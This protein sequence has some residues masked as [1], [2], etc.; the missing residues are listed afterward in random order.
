LLIPGSISYVF[1]IMMTSLCKEYYQFIL[2]QGVL[3]GISTGFLFTPSLAVISHYFRK[4]RG[5]AMGVCSAGASLGGLLFPIGLKHALYSERLGFQW[6]VRV[7]GFTILGLLC[8]SCTLL[9]GRLPPRRGKLLLLRAFRQPS[10][11]ILISAIF[12]S[13]WATWVPYFFIVSFAL[14][15]IHT[16][17]NLSFYIFP[18]L[19][20]GLSLDESFRAS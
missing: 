1:S 3:G 8:I 7:I 11:S 18:S 2:A 20:R 5:F 13:L 17:A 4:K 10:Y 12:L 19:T 16:D 14:E 15:K 6:G 9:E